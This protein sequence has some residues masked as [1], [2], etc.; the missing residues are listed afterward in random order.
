MKKKKFKAGQAIVYE[1]KWFKTKVKG[2]KLGPKSPIA[3]GDVVHVLA[4]HTPAIGHCI[5]TH[6]D[7]RIVT[8]L[9]PEDFRAATDDEV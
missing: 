8:M 7:G 6:Y 4:E 5:V 9:H 3:Y 1:P 2:A